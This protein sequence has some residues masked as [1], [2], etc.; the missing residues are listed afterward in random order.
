MDFKIKALKDCIFFGSSFVKEEGFDKAMRWDWLCKEGGPLWKGQTLALVEEGEK[1]LLEKLTDFLSYLSGAATLAGCFTRRR[2]SK[3]AGSSTKNSF[4]ARYFRALQ[5]GSPASEKTQTEAFGP[6]SG[7][8]LSK[9][10]LVKRQA[11]E[12]QFSAFI[13][14]PKKRRLEDILSFFKNHPPDSLPP[15]L[16]YWEERA[17]KAGG[18]FTNPSLPQNILSTKNS[19]LEACRQ[20]EKKLLF[21]DKHSG[22]FK[23]SRFAA[24]KRGCGQPVWP[25]EP[26]RLQVS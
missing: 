9:T 4:Y 15:A 6:L 17:L 13:P 21:S 2:L 3:T 11:S 25:F 22:F 26:S 14:P 10:S 24:S 7:A 19:V 1:S 20:G 18:V 8:E 5:N 12:K 23:H 16:H